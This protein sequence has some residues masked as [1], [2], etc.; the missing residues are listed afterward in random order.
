MYLTINVYPEDVTP[1]AFTERFKLID[2]ERFDQLAFYE[3]PCGD[4]L[5][6]NRFTGYCL[7]DEGVSPLPLSEPLG[8]FHLESSISLM[9][10]ITDTATEND[11]RKLRTLIN[12]RFK[13]KDLYFNIVL[14]SM[15]IVECR[16]VTKFFKVSSFRIEYIISTNEFLL[17]GK[18]ENPGNLG[19]TGRVSISKVLGGEEIKKESLSNEDIITLS[20]SERDFRNYLLSILIYP[21]H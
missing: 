11:I 1:I 13:Q 20:F 3:S 16:R 18:L 7:S 4:V 5:T 19:I 17:I 10:T 2:D 21:V 12:T 8:C 9:N 15:S 14:S 6:F